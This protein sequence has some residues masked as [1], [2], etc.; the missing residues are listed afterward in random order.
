MAASP[1]RGDG[2]TELEVGVAL[3][4]C[5]DSHF[6]VLCF[7][8]TRPLKARQYCGFLPR[9]LWSALSSF[10]RGDVFPATS[11]HRVK[12][13][14]TTTF[15]VPAVEFIPDFVLR[16]FREFPSQSP[17]VALP[18]ETSN[19]LRNRMDDETK[20]LLPRMHDLVGNQLMGSLRPFQFIG[21]NFVIH[22]NGRAL[23]GDEMGLGKTLQALAAAA[24]YQDDWPMLVVAPA[25]VR[26][27]WR[28]QAARWLPHLVRNPDAD[29][30]V[31]R[32]GKDAVSKR[33]KIVIISY[34]MLSRNAAFQNFGFN[35]IVVDES[36][37]LK[38]GDAKRSQNILPML[39]R[40]RRVLL[41]SGTPAMNKPSELFTQVNAVIP[42]FACHRDFND[43]FCH[44]KLNQWS[45]RV[46]YT[47]S[48][49]SEELHVY[50]TNTV[51]IRRLK[52][53]V[54]KELPPKMRSRIPVELAASDMR[55]LSRR[56]EHVGDAFGKRSDGDGVIT[57]QVSE[58]FALT[59][60]AKLKAAGDYVKYVLLSG[61]KFLVFAHHRT[62]LDH[63][64]KVVLKENVD[65]IRIDG[66]VSQDK[67]EAQVRHFSTCED[68]RVAILSIT[69]A[70][71]GLNLTAA[72]TVV[73]AE[74]YWVPGQMMQAE[75]RAH[76]MGTEFHSID[77]HYLIAVGTIDEQIWKMLNR[78]WQSMTSTLDGQMEVIQAT[79]HETRQITLESVK[80][81]AMHSSAALEDVR[82]RKFEG[83]LDVS[84]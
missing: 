12:E 61:C 15:E 79:E 18:N 53:L 9:Q 4:L 16:V 63:L 21:L 69:A 25:S 64:E 32:S 45:R 65:Y 56:L 51:M 14:I 58:L 72:G 7:Q 30:M 20:A 59:A 44:K 60:Q 19:I 47:G 84:V 62:M 42:H 5:D 39:Q 76:R 74:L 71:V 50:L 52:S 48:K 81:R 49:H 46:E 11:Y 27:Q 35:M 77:I 3:V 36:H 67:R 22:N 68:C 31:V 2:T 73:F 83:S 28:D 80:Q 23:I 24:F 41:L 82:R 8:E 33:A 13:V 26:F 57:P 10:K 40:A 38:S 43:R 55:E 17:A 29:I 78:K 6:R 34:E 54:Q 75:D 1:P 37:Y 70:G 66:S